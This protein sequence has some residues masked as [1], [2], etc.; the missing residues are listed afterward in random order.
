MAKYAEILFRHRIRFVALLLIPI[1][2]GS[3]I[4]VLFASY[5]AAATLSI[6]DPSA[7]GAT[8]VPLGWST[9]QTPAQNLADSVNLV[10]KTTAFTQSLSDSLA[11]T[12]AVSSQSE[13]RQT[14]ASI[15][16]N[17]KVAASGAHLM[18]LTYSCPRAALCLQVVSNTIDIFRQQLTQ[19]KQAQADAASAFWA[20]QLKDAQANLATAQTAL[21]RYAAANPSVPLNANS[22]DPQ[23][24]QLLD[25]VAQWRAKV[26]ES[27]DNLSQAQYLAT[28][29][30]R[31]LQ[32]GTNVVDPPHMA[33]RFYG[34]GTSLVPAALDLAGGTV[35]DRG[36][37][38]HAGLGGQD[39]RRPQGPRA[40]PGRASGG[41]NTEPC[42]RTWLLGSSRSGQECRQAEGPVH[43]KPGR[44]QL[45]ESD[46]LAM[47]IERLAMGQVDQDAGPVS[48][49][50]AHATIGNEPATNRSEQVAKRTE[51]VT[52]GSD[53]GTNG[54]RHVTNANDRVAIPGWTGCTTGVSTLPAATPARCRRRRARCRRRRAG[55]RLER[56]DSKVTGHLTKGTD[57]L[58]KESEQLTTEFSQSIN[59]A[60]TRRQTLP[61]FADPRLERINSI[62]LPPWFIDRCRNAYLSVRFDPDS[63]CRVLGVTSAAYGEGKTSVAIGIATAMALDTKKPTLLIECDFA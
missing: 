45:S 1:A 11:S 10:I 13:L 12:N 61:G 38:V 50:S 14:L 41:D 35:C 24:V 29:S 53:P 6:E 16:T 30:A 57:Q 32:V 39:G 47:A 20:A 52:L 27:Q 40:P 48:N 60:L 4:A 37:R 42:E 46:R 55:C 58:T 9:S 56:A 49:G 25:G 22:S 33:S 19:T 62:E 54:S 63:E 28:A 21:Q 26:V 44:E 17:M 36:L 5:R 59:D 34:D 23:V 7:F 15:P 43:G 2:L 3:S 31:L 18:T 51:Q 8:F